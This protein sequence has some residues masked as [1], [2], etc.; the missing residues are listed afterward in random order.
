MERADKILR[1][2]CDLIEALKMPDRL[3][4]AGFRERYKARHKKILEDIGKL[5][6]DE[7]VYLESKYQDW[8]NLKIKGKINE[9]SNLI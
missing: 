3:E 2:L 4:D 8:F 5:N 7:Y 6:P 1:E 9:S